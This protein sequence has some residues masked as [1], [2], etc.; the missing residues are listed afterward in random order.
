MAVNVTQG[1]IW[2]IFF[3]F[4]FKEEISYWQASFWKPINKMSSAAANDVKVAVPI[5]NESN[6]N[7][8][9]DQMKFWL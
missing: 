6:Y 3:E 7:I 8:W 2:L 1:V 9:V 5:F 4:L